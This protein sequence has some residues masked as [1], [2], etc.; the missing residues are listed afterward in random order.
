VAAS[1]LAAFDAA[2]FGAPEIIPVL[3]SGGA[4]R[5]T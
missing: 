1:V 3:P 2:G 5:V 4:H